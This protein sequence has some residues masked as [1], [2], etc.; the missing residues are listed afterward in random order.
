MSK[1]K[2]VGEMGKYYPEI[3]RY[4]KE[5]TGR[6]IVYGDYYVNC[7]VLTM[8]EDS[9]AGDVIYKAMKVRE[10]KDDGTLYSGKNR[11]IRLLPI[12]RVYKCVDPEEGDTV[13]VY[14]QTKDDIGM[15]FG[16]GEITS[17]YNSK[18]ENTYSVYMSDMSNR[19]GISVTLHKEFL[20]GK[21]L[22]KLD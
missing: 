17:K 21:I 2:H 10:I 6:R 15:V 12:C 8:V 14:R 16:V 1:G 7:K 18:G 13:V 22:E 11:D 4:E 20:A 3:R 9:T 19:P 5:Y